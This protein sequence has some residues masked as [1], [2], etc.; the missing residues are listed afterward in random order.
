MTATA[1]ARA[2]RTR[3]TWPTWTTILGAVGVAVVVNLLVHTLGRAAGGT[4][5]FT[6]AAGGPATVDL[7]TVAGFTAVPLLVGLVL[8]V[9]LRR[10]SWVIPTALV[11][12][13]V[14]AVGT[15][16]AMTL[17]AD[18]DR[19]S[20]VALACCHLVVGVVAVLALRSL[21]D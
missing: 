2:V 4:F 1:T 8:A 14:I 18:F 9:M 13:P 15:I 3:P 17:P 12:A 10:W 21:R 16:A 20:T 19:I 5:D 11:V 6:T 7:A